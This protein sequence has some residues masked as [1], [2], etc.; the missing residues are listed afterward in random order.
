MQTPHD[1]R[2][3]RLQNE[4]LPA[5]RQQPV[6]PKVPTPA[7]PS[8]DTGIS[9]T[10]TNASRKHTRSWVL[11]SAAGLQIRR[12]PWFGREDRAQVAP[13]GEKAAGGQ[14]GQV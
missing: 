6:G 2:A 13:V 3:A 8:V 9:E 1:H 7:I 10:T 14:R 4:L 11:A 5:R 12:L